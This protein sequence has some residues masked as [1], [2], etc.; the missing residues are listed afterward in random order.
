MP[1]RFLR[2]FH[3]PLCDHSVFQ[4][5]AQTVSSLRTAGMLRRVEKPDEAL[6]VELLATSAERLR[7]GECGETGLHISEARDEFDWPEAK[8]CERCKAEIPAERLEIFP[9]GKLCVK[10]QSAGDAGVSSD[11]PE[12]CPRCGGLLQMRQAGGSG[13]ARYVMKCSDCGMSA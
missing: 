2:E 10:C 4:D 6:V 1:E 13:L 3:C 5:F 8:K 9:D 12:F 7:C 11:E